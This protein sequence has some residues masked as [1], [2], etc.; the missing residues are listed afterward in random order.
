[1][2]SGSAEEEEEEE[3]ESMVIFCPR[4]PRLSIGRLSGSGFCNIVMLLVKKVGPVGH[5]DR[6]L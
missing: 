6:A 2:G 4:T 1:L 3:V 5:K